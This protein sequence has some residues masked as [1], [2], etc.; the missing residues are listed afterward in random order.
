MLA[1]CKFRLGE[2]LEAIEYY[3]KSLSLKLEHETLRQLADIY[4]EISDY[5][6]AISTV[7]QAIE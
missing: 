7:K 5:D 6:N 4:V 1:K 2:P 3:E